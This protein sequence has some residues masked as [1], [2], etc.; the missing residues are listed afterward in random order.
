MRATSFL[1]F[2]AYSAKYADSME[3]KVDFSKRLQQISTLLAYTQVEGFVPN[4]KG[5]ELRAA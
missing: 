5:F 1:K 2:Q 4:V 3:F